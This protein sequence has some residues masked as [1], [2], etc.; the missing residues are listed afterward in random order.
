MNPSSREILFGLSVISLQPEYSLCS[1][2]KAA[3]L[4]ACS[5]VSLLLEEVLNQNVGHAD[6][7]LPR[8]ETEG[9]SM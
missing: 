3:S 6:C 4:A 5:V 2:R 1:L 7:L 8:G 9:T